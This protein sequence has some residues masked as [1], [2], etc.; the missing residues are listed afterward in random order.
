MKSVGGIA[1]DPYPR[2]TRAV[3]WR[4]TDL[5]GPYFLRYSLADGARPWEHVGDDPDEA[6]AA[7][8]RKRAH[9]ETLDANRRS[10]SRASPRQASVCRSS[11]LAVNFRE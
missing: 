6:I 2:Q 7:R 8:E 5:A 11:V 9:F 3:H 4:P 10:S 1:S